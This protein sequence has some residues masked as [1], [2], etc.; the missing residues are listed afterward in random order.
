MV[1]NLLMQNDFLLKRWNAG[2]RLETLTF[3]CEIK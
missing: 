2:S 3:Y 1:I